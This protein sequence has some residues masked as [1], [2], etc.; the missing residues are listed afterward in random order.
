MRQPCRWQMRCTSDRPRP[1]PSPR[2]GVAAHEGLEH[3]VALLARDAD[4]GIDHAE[5]AAAQHQADEAAGRCSGSRCAAGWRGRR[6]AAA[7]G[8]VRRPR[9]PRAS[10]SSRPRASASPRKRPSSSSAICCRPSLAA[11]PQGLTF[12]RAR[13]FE[14]GRHQLAHLHA[15]SARMRRMAVSWRASL[16]PCASI[17]SQELSITISG[18]RSSWLTSLVN[19]RSRCSACRSLSSVASKAAASLPTSSGA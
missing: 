10:D 9:C 5:A 16:I 19:R 11:V 18:V 4:A 3:G 7:P 12:R 17:S 13:Q 8:S 14:E 6:A 1:M 15:G 2:A